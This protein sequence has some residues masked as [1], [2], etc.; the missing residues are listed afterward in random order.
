MLLY[1][2]ASQAVL[3]WPSTWE[4]RQVESQGQARCTRWWELLLLLC[5]RPTGAHWITISA[6]FKTSSTSRSLP[7]HCG[8]LL[9]PKP[10]YRKSKEDPVNW[11]KHQSQ[12]AS[13]FRCT[14]AA[15]AVCCW[16]TPCPAFVSV[17]VS[18][19]CRTSQSLHWS[20]GWNVFHNRPQSISESQRYGHDW[21][22]KNS[23]SEATAGT[24]CS[25]RAVLCESSSTVDWHALLSY[26]PSNPVVS[27]SG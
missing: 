6:Y 2:E 9:V 19:C 24:V 25:Q 17:S 14:E 16:Y 3:P 1:T 18:G 13:C 8:K 12:K 21:H 26:Q 7:G 22:S 4:H 10:F 23:R 20:I 15:T 27:V 11:V 5:R